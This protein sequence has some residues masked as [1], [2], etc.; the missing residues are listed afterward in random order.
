MAI[1]YDMTKHYAEFGNAFFRGR[2]KGATGEARFKLIADTIN[3]VDTVNIAGQSVTFSVTTKYEN[4]IGPE[5]LRAVINVPD[6][7]V[8][9]EFICYGVGVTG[10]LLD[11]VARGNFNQ[12]SLTSRTNPY[13]EII[14]VSKGDHTV[15]LIGAANTMSSSGFVFCRYIRKTGSEAL[16]P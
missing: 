4:K 7:N 15:Q 5:F 2:L 12:R 14:A 3:A 13:N 6:D 16:N 8:Y 10:F 1:P 11:G 9:L